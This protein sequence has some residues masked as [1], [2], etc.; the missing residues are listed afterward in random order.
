MAKPHSVHSDRSSETSI[1]GLTA[2]IALRDSA[3]VG[4]ARQVADLVRRIAQVLTLDAEAA[5][6]LSIAAQLHD[7][8]CIGLSDAVLARPLHRLGVDELRR[9]R[10]HPVLGEKAVL[11]SDMHSVAPLLRS[12]HER[13][14]G[15]GFP[16]GL[17][18][19]AIPLGARILA[20][21]DAY[22]D[23]AT[24]HIDGQPRCQLDASNAVIGGRST[25]FD[26]TVIDAFA[27]L[28]SVALPS[29]SSPS[30]RLRTADL[31]TGQTLTEDLMSPEG[32]LLLSAGHR[33]NNDLIDRI[34]A[35]ERKNG[36]AVTLCVQLPNEGSP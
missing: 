25:R 12:H 17:R 29:T 13:W 30:L 4:H 11:A 14:D 22:E 15:Q 24:G 8:G 35:F 10:Q 36:A 23:L 31:R 16:D 21:A 27:S 33:L 5:R 19:A 7:I 9:Y 32:V 2:L 3:Q 6:D 20:V 18:G 34:R 26:P 28:I 1:N